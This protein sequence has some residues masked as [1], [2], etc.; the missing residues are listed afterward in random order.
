MSRTPSKKTAVENAASPKTHSWAI[1]RLKGTPAALLGHVEAPDAEA[2]IKKGIEAFKI[3]PAFH[4][5]LIA[6]RRGWVCRWTKD[7]KRVP[8]ESLSSVLGQLPVTLPEAVDGHARRGIVNK[9][10][11]E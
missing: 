5:R 2:A 9:P 11:G 1:Y 7:V 6:Q 10:S 3:D 4:K 8:V